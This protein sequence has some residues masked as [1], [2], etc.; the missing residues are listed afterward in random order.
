METDEQLFERL[1]EEVNR[2]MEPP[3]FPLWLLFKLIWKAIKGERTH[4]V[5]LSFPYLIS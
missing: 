3:R 2:V 4:T 5:E 1:D